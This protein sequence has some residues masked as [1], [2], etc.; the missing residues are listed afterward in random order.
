MVTVVFGHGFT[1]VFK[2]IF[3]NKD[4]LLTLV[5]VYNVL[6]CDRTNR[7]E[8]KSLATHNN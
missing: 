7:N 4:R 5:S 6:L 1:M 8:S 3:L 2:D